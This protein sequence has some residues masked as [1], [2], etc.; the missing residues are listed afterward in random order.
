MNRSKQIGTAGES[1][2]VGYLRP[3][4][5][6]GAERR[7]LAGVHDLGD[8]TGTGPLCWEVKA[9]GAAANASDGQVSKW[10]DETEVE[11][12]NAQADY[13]LLVMKRAGIGPARAGE[14]WAVLPAWQFLSLQGIRHSPVPADVPIRLHLQDAVTILRLAGYGDALLEDRTA[15]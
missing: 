7:A 13:G 12:Q 1:A 11:R 8:I 6:P 15:A 5:F 14:W 10:L 2:V 4:G 3:N 9:G